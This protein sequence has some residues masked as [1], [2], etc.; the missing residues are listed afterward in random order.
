LSREKRE[1]EL[2][3]ITKENQDILKRIM[4]K[5]PEETSS[6]AYLKKDW[7][8]N[9]KFLDNISAFPQDWYKR[10]TTNIYTSRSGAQNTNRPKLGDRS[11]TLNNLSSNDKSNL[12][13]SKEVSS[14][15][16]DAKKYDDEFE[17]DD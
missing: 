10:D 9:V 1:R 7:D 12:N 3:R 17:K 16:T 5:K 15:D 8:Q 11:Q 6:A 4:S 2:L 13:E 14:K